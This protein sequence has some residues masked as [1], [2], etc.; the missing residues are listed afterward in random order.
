MKTKITVSKRAAGY[1]ALV[2]Y[3]WAARVR[4]L[5]Y[6]SKALALQAA[7]REIERKRDYTLDADL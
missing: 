3:P 1:T 5:G 6:G 7:E 2:V 4:L